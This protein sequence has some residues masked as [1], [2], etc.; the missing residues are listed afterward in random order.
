MPQNK[1]RRNIKK[2]GRTELDHLSFREEGQQYAHVIRNLGGCNLEVFCYDG[3]TR[4]AHIRGKMRK[5]QWIKVGD[6][7]LVGTRDYQDSKC[8][9]IYKYKSEEVSRLKRYGEITHLSQLDGD[10]PEE[11]CFDFD[12]I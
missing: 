10:T 9:V 3:T 8:D 6:T 5:R 4:I 2:S 11:C 12:D 7:V 1:T